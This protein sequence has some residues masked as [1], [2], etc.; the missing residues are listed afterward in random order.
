MSDFTVVID[1]YR[2]TRCKAVYAFVPKPNAREH[3]RVDDENPSDGCST[4]YVD[5]GPRGLA[6]EHCDGELE[7]VSYA[8]EAT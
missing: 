2:C 8:K 5:S 1:L 7:S 3:Y 6:I 4:L